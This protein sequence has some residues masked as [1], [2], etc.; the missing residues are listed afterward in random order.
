MPFRDWIEAKGVAAVAERLRVSTKTVTNW[1]D[2]ICDPRVDQ[3][4]QIRRWSKGLVTYEAII[5]RPR[6]GPRPT[7]LVVAR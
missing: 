4:R 5:D 1:R 6:T 2:G 7:F 3:M